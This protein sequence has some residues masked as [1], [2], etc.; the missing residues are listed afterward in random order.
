MRQAQS[1]Y[2]SKVAK[3]VATLLLFGVR[4]RDRLSTQN[5]FTFLPMHLIKMGKNTVASS[6]MAKAEI[7]MKAGRQL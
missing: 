7:K 5:H 2:G 6:S 1:L 3:Q 4:K